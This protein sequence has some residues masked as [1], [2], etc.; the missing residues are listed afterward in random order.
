MPQHF[1]IPLSRVKQPVRDRLDV[2]PPRSDFIKAAPHIGDGLNH[3][4]VLPNAPRLARLRLVD[5]WRWIGSNGMNRRLMVAP[6]VMDEAVAP[7]SE[8]VV[9]VIDRRDGFIDPA[10]TARARDG[11]DFDCPELVSEIEAPQDIGRDLIARHPACGTQKV[12]DRSFQRRPLL[13]QD[14]NGHGDGDQIGRASPIAP[15]FGG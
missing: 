3:F 9:D 2:H 4:F 6:K 1:G 7:V 13:A 12:A 8:R 15:Q 14:A 11:G 5:H 10:R